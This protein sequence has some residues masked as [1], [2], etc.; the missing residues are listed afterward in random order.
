[1]SNE[2]IPGVSAPVNGE[3]IPSSFTLGHGQSAPSASPAA[4]Y[5]SALAAA[6]AAVDRA[7][8]PYER[9]KARAL[10]AGYDRRWLER[11]TRA[12]IITVETEF[13]YRLLNPETGGQSQSF[14][15]AGKIDA[16][17]EEDGRLKI[18][19][20]KTAGESIDPAASYWDRLTLDTQI[21]AYYIAAETGLGLRPES[22]VYDVIRKPG[23]QATD[24]PVLDEAGL[25]IVIDL[26][27]GERALNKN[28]SPRQSG[29]E[30]YQMRL[31]PMTAEEYEA[32]LT[33]DI[34]ERPEFYF[35]QREAA[36]LDADIMEYMADAWAQGQMI[37]Y[38]RN[39]NLWPRNPSSCTV[40]GICPFFDLCAGHAAVDGL[41]YA[42][43]A[44][45]HKEL[46]SIEE[47]GR[48]LLTNSRLLDLRSCARKH[49]LRYEERIERVGEEA[50][51]LRFG[52]LMHNGLEAWLSWIKQ[53]QTK[54]EK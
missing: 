52:T 31:R 12:R 35:A 45:I 29:G 46:E 40:L 26:A 16:I 38:F 33:G 24:V 47:N 4:L 9:V 43:G 19:E 11:F 41:R 34:G 39:R 30:G 53:D 2:T 48:A 20:H 27:T 5:P 23:L 54:E 36:R 21:S 37:L 3:F 50:E 15:A 51:A 7:A 44:K 22:V 10:L 17:I 8:D 32:K 42:R 14:D 1:M 49:Q 13:Q 28:G 25:K 6:Y 18:V